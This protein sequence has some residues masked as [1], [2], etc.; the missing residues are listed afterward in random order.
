[1]SFKWFGFSIFNLITLLFSVTEG[2]RGLQGID[3]I[4]RKNYE[5][6]TGKSYDT[7]AASNRS[8]YVDMSRRF[9]DAS[10]NFRSLMER[11][12]SESTHMHDPLFGTEINAANVMPSDYGREKIIPSAQTY[13]ERER[14]HAMARPIEPEFIRSSHHF[15]SVPP[16]VKAFHHS[17]PEMS[18]YNLLNDEFSIHQ[19]TS[20]H[21]SLPNLPLSKHSSDDRKRPAKDI[22]PIPF[23]QIQIPGRAPYKTTLSESFAKKFPTATYSSTVEDMPPSS[24][25]AGKPGQRISRDLMECLDKMTYHSIADDNPF[26]P[27][28]LAPQQ[29]T[30]LMLRRSSDIS[31]ASNLFSPQHNPLDESER[32]EFAEG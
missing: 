25:S 11:P 10:A 23:E 6:L 9:S 15:P 27:I 24:Q 13:R 8:Q 21:H 19:P 32:D 16:E 31:G 3:A 18:Y 28:P 22:E 7:S 2:Q 12:I 1:M 5:M 4:N 20:M 17:Y 30:A 26:E 29:E 14:A